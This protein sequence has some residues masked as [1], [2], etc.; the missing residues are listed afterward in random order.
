MAKLAQ[1][2]GRRQTPNLAARL[3]ASAEPDAVVI[4]A[5][6]CRLVGDLFEVRDLGA[7]EVKGIAAPVEAWQV[8]RPGIRVRARRDARSQTVLLLARAAPSDEDATASRSERAVTLPARPFDRI[9]LIIRW[10][11]RVHC[12]I[13][14]EFRDI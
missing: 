5:G 8:F 4:A 9:I 3:Q 14:P 6:T 12:K 1:G 13:A 11:K 10:T 7:V 2:H